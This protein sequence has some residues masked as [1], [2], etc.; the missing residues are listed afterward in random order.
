MKAWILLTALL[1]NP[2]ISS[3]QTQKTLIGFQ[4]IP[5][6]SSI[7]TIKTKFQNAKEEDFCKSRS[8]TD[9]NYQSLKKSL[10]EKNLS[11]ISLKQ[12]PYEI[13]GIKFTV[14]FSMDSTNR[15][16]SVE[17]T[18]GKAQDDNK[19]YIFEC[20]SVFNRVSHLLEA[21]YGTSIVVGNIDEFGKDYLNYSA[22]SWL[23]FPTQV[24]IAKLS[25]DR[26]LKSLATSLNKPESDACKV[27]IN[28][29]R[30]IPD[31][32]SKL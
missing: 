10:N 20:T 30:S 23:P 8:D 27:I 4:G 13:D 6:G 15:L 7:Q 26:F 16:K 21:R 31:E 22:K 14:A 17:L 18:F 5:W 3:G 32:A 2:I 29:S 19:N 11:C 28:Y 12:Y 9:K 24:W 1:I 25:G